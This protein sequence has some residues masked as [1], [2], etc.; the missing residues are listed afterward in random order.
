MALARRLK[1]L[2]QQRFPGRPITQPQLA[3]AL[4]AQRPVSV[5][6]I[7]S[8]ESTRSPVA[9]PR[10]RLE[11][12][13][14]LFA[15]ER[16]IDHGQVRML[17]LADLSADE[18][19]A[20]ND[21]RTELLELRERASAV[22]PFDAAPPI[23]DGREPPRGLIWRF[24]SEQD[25]TIVCAQL[26]DAVLTDMPFADPASPDYVAM[27]SYADLDS[28]VE[29]HGHIRACC[30][31]NQVN[32]RTAADVTPDDYSS[33]LVLLGGVD[34]NKLTGS[35]F[36]ALDLPVTQV[37][38][39]KEE[40]K[41]GFLVDVGGK[42]RLYSPV[43]HESGGRQELLEDVALFYRGRN[44]YNRKRT[45]TIF[46]GMYGRGTQG[47][48]RALTDARFRDRNEEH[49]LERLGENDAISLVTRISILNGQ[50]ATPDWTDAGVRLHEWPEES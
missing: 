36:R 22:L 16:S 5:P 27:Y 33:H 19:L 17:D 13:A 23:V 14:R 6:S 21:L 41:G 40:D 20:Y 18:R 35:V 15:T 34:W 47:A 1:W 48:V 46:N 4:G 7:S 8:W 12:Y 25:I 44:P 45:V 50:A 9:P 2:R 24:P 11:A 39:E 31:A 29:L 37:G 38:R 43:L 3:A 28:L 10:S 26:P 49:L 30:P 42:Q 32:I